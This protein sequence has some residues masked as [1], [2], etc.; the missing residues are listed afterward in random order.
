MTFVC[1]KKH[2]DLDYGGQEDAHLHM[3][4]AQTC[5]DFKPRDTPAEPS[6]QRGSE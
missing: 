5:P 3:L 6:G 2:W 4:K 1:D